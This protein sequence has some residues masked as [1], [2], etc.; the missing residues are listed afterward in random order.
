MFKFLIDGV[1]SWLFASDD[2]G[3]A[4]QYGPSIDHVHKRLIELVNGFE[5]LDFFAFDKPSECMDGKVNKSPPVIP[6]CRAI[7]PPNLMT[8]MNDDDDDE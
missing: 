1:W 8:M 4:H 2:D 7:D 3:S 6:Q 5:L